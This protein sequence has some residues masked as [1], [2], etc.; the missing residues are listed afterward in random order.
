M[1]VLPE[2]DFANLIGNAGIHHWMST[3]N[4]VWALDVMVYM[5]E[6]GHNLWLQHAFLSDNSGDYSSHMS[7]TGWEPNLLGPLKCYNAASNRRMGC[8]SRRTHTVNLHDNNNGAQL[9][10]LAAFSESDK[11]DKSNPVLV[12]VGE[13]SLQYNFASSNPEGTAQDTLER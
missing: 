6:L 4:Y 12:Q 7:A 3:L 11:A 1:V 13:Y 9:V 8:F 2:N 10:N 5:H